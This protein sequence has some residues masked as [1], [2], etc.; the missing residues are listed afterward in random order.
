MMTNKRR[1]TLLIGSISVGSVMSFFMF[2]MKRG[3]TLTANDWL[4]LGSIFI[5]SIILLV[6]ISIILNKADKEKMK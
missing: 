2:K 1:Y 4:T 5:I 6:S 3:G